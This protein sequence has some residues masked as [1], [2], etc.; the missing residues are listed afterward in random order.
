MARCEEGYRCEVCGQ[1][2]ESLAES[3]LYLR[4]V[5]G[6]L[7]AEVLHTTA[8]R[9]I[10]CNPV[11]AQFIHD[12]RFDPVEVEGPFDCRTLDPQYVAHRQSLVTRGYQRL[13]ELES[14]GGDRD[15]TGYPLPEVIDRYRDR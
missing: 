3:D 2:V 9:H 12:P 8:E 11:L 1:D 5:I 6:E 15:V 13:Q 10:R 4:F 14:L 7:E